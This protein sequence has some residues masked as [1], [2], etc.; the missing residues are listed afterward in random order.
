MDNNEN[1]ITI[2]FSKLREEAK[3]LNESY[4][5]VFG[6]YI[7]YALEKMF[8]SGIAPPMT[9][10]GNPNEIKSF[11]KVLTREKRYADAYQKH[12]LNDPKTF[13]NKH[14]LELAVKQFERAT[15][16]KWPFK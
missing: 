10:R 13:S 2:D 5:T 8:G 9:I 14:K 6:T 4:F 7:Q 3:V 15:K 1:K 16:L 12:G 11:M